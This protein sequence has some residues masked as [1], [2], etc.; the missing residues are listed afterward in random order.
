MWNGDFLLG[1]FTKN[2]GVAFRSTLEE[3]RGL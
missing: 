2:V 3:F 1:K